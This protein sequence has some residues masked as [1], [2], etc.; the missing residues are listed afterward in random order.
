LGDF[1]AADNDKVTSSMDQ[2]RTRR[3]EVG[4]QFT[5][6][7]VDQPT[8]LCGGICLTGGDPIVVEPGFG[9]RFTFNL[10][11]NI[12]VEAEGNYYTR[13]RREL[14]NPSGH[15]FQGQF[16]AKVG[17]R[18]DKWGVFGKAR[19]GFVGF[20]QVSELFRTRE[21]VFFGRTFEVG[22]FRV[23]KDFY[24]SVDVGGVLELYI[25]SRWMA[26]FDIGDTIIRYREIQTNGFSLSEAIVRRPPETQHNL[27]VTSGIGF[28]F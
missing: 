14:P 24:P 2:E 22:E 1:P 26:R 23:V 5:S 7:L 6:M 21:I 4:A 13:N 12:A 17:K 28:R 9:G 18:F 19:P 27:Q 3:F 11:D 15:M 10:T 20:T 25:S 16:G 8:R